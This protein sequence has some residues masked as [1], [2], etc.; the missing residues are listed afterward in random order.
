[1]SIEQAVP[2]AIRADEREAGREPARLVIE[3]H[4]FQLLVR[5]VTP[6]LPS[7]ERQAP[8]VRNRLGW[9]V[10]GQS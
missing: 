8:R 6:K 1:M 10:P 9:S 3:P 7:R 4:D 5:E 2:A